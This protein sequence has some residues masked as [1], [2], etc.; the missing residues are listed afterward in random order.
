M[1]MVAWED[2]ENKDETNDFVEDMNEE[3][4]DEK[5]ETVQMQITDMKI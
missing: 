1:L 3:T 4:T 5:I 2:P